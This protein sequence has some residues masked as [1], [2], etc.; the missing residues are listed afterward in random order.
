[1]TA[2]APDG[3]AAGRPTPEEPAAGR[4]PV[5]VVVPVR[6]EAP[7]LRECL[8]RLGA[9]AEVI[10]VDSGSTDESLRIAAEAGARVLHFR[11]DGRFPKKRNW[12]LLNH[13]P[14]QPWVLFL[15]AD[16]FVPEAFC[17]ALAAELPFS[18]KDG[19]WIGYTTHFQGRRLRYGIE[20]RKLALF[21]VGKALYERI[22]DTGW[23]SLDME[24]H[25]QPVVAGPVGRILPPIDHRD[26]RGIAHFVAKHLEYAR[27]EARR[28]ALLR[29]RPDAAWAGLSGRQRMKYRFLDRWWWAWLYFFTAYGAK[30]GFLDGSAGFHH[31]FYKLWYFKTIRVIMRENR[32]AGEARPDPARRAASPA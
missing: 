25:E 11:W 8:G 28:H 30:L 1:V 3:P 9:F 14:S 32:R 24:V 31:A 20:Q 5:T 26:D 27:W 23:T 12:V 13:L 18:D 21:R 22:E 17:A 29:A 19:Y 7:R 16:E 10:V 15:D 6:N 2:R 4:L